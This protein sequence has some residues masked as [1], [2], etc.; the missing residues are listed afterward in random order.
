MPN[1]E[2]RKQA[3]EAF[4]QELKDVLDWNTGRTPLRYCCRTLRSYFTPAPGEPLFPV[5]VSLPHF[6]FK[7]WAT[8]SKLTLLGN[9][10]S[11][12]ELC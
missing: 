7:G 2:R 8:I 1:E 4:Q 5:G 10:P 11:P 12:S 6:V 3:L 9:L